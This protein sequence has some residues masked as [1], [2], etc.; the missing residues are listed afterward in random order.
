M[1]IIITR[2]APRSWG[3]KDVEANTEKLSNIYT[4][5]IDIIS[6]E[7]AISSTRGGLILNNRNW[8][9]FTYVDNVDP[10]ESFT[11]TNATDLAV[12]L[13]ELEG[14]FLHGSSEG[15]GGST[16]F[17]IQFAQDA[18]ISTLLGKAG[19]SLVV[20]PTGSHFELKQISGG[21]TS[22]TQLQEWQAG[23]ALQPQKFL[24]TSND[25]TKILQGDI[26]LV[27]N[28]PIA[29]DEFRVVAKGTQGGVPNQEE[30]VKEIGDFCEG[31]YSGDGRNYDLIYKGGDQS[32]LASY[33]IRGWSEPL[34]I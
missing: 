2:Y 17:Y 10:S 8:A 33:E 24:L 11:P 27:V 9:E 1:A 29:V 18:V 13:N 6:G 4:G 20:D 26:D 3:I 5:I 32:L 16:D 28:T 22:I 30:Y 19:Y 23:D 21:A 12:R 31:V 25:A 34:T 14:F 7:V 15:G